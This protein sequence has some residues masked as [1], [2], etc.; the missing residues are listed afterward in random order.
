M[1]L[2]KV[3]KQCRNS[4]TTKYLIIDGLS[5]MEYAAWKWADKDSAG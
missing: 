4:I 3:T 5:D 1:Y 2:I